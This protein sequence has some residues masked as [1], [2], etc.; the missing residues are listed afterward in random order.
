MCILREIAVQCVQGKQQEIS[1]SDLQHLA[2]TE[3]QAWYSAQDSRQ[4]SKVLF[5]KLQTL[6][7]QHISFVA[8]GALLQTSCSITHKT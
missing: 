2:E 6:C 7:L 1:L 4:V 5:H 8:C 3:Q